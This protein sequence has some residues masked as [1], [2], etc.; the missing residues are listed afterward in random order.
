MLDVDMI[1]NSHYLRSPHSQKS[2]PV[3]QVTKCPRIFN[4]KWLRWP[5]KLLIIRQPPSREE[6]G[7]GVVGG[8]AM[9][10]AQH[11][12]SLINK[13]VILGQ[14][15]R[16]QKPLLPSLFDRVADTLLTGSFLHTNVLCICQ[17]SVLLQS[18]DLQSCMACFLFTFHQPELAGFE[19]G[20]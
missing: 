20:L 4:E 19:S 10:R 3:T 11:L 7:L 18:W 17:Q 16:G 2:L 6:A 14:D 1:I 8:R 12:A 13:C 5:S 9:E 15:S